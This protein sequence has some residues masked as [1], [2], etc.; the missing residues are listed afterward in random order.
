VRSRPAPGRP[1]RRVRLARSGRRRKGSRS[2]SR[3]LRD[4]RDDRGMATVLACFCA[5]A[6]IALMLVAVQLGAA[7]VARERAEAA[8]DLGA[9]AGAA[10]VLGGAQAACNAVARVVSA[11]GGTLG[12]C[13]L[14]GADIQVVATVDVGI[15]P[16]SRR[17]EARARAGPV[18]EQAP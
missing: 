3:S 15:G 12:S 10:S 8:A 7:T 14:Q 4:P 18:A 1:A 5:M 6:L 2:V 9:L 16:L 13:V 11:N 17:A